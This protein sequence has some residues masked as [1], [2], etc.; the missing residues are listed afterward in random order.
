MAPAALLN[1][2]PVLLIM[3]PAWFRAVGGDPQIAGP[4]ALAPVLH[5][6]V[7]GVTQLLMTYTA[8]RMSWAEQLPPDE[9][10]WL[11]RATATLWL[12][13]LIGGSAVYVVRYIV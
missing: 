4:L 10:I 13:A 11:M 1:W 8:I 9:P 6:V 5:G 12:L 7:G 2:I 3:L